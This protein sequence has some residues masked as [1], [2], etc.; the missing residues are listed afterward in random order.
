MAAIQAT[1]DHA[2]EGLAELVEA[3]DELCAYSERSAA[4]EPPMRPRLML[5]KGGRG[6]A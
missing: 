3:V 2:G 4:P 5:I 1:I 6:D